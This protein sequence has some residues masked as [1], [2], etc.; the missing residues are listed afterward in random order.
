MTTKAIIIDDEPLAQKIIENYAQQIPSLEIVCKCDN[1]LQAVDAL[2]KHDVDLL[3]L[4]IN[5]PQFNGLSL[6]K[7]L[8]DP[9]LVIITTAYTEYALECFELDVLDYLKKPFSFERFLKAVLKVENTLKQLNKQ[10]TATATQIHSDE[11]FFVKSNKKTV[12]INFCDICYVEAL[13]DYIK[14]VTCNSN[15][16]TNLSMKKINEL[17]PKDS[18]YRIHKSFIVALNQI[19]AIEGNMVEIQK[20]KI[21]IGASFRSDFFKIIQAYTTS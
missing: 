1:A 15:I 2:H 4:D 10:P 20:K 19:D 3:F 9:P 6:L 14:I 21:P 5:M 17:L 7:T 12:K 13:G 16:V 18:F 11:F 8:K